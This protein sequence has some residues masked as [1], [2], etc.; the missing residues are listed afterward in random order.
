MSARKPAGTL[1]VELR[2][3]GDNPQWAVVRWRDGPMT[4]AVV[5]THDSKPD[6]IKACGN[7]ALCDQKRARAA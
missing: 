2:R 1:S 7:V 4:Y 6:A 3:A 5:S